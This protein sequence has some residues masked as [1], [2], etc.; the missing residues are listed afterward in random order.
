MVG[1]LKCIGLVPFIS[2]DLERRVSGCTCL[3]S[4]LLN[5]IEEDP[6]VVLSFFILVL[7]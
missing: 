1:A 2:I 4:I 3:P 7:E 5:M 6:A